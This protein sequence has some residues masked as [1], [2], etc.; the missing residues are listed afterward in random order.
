MRYCYASTVQRL[1]ADFLPQDLF[2][3]FT[4]NNFLHA[5]VEQ[6]VTLILESAPQET[7]EGNSS[8]PLLEQVTQD[9]GEGNRRCRVT[10]ERIT[11]KPGGKRVVDDKLRHSN[12]TRDCEKR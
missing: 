6:C 2:F 12:R 5:Q 7:G 10:R 3:H 8:H 11:V 1:P 4:L 9:T